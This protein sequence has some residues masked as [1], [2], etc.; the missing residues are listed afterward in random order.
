MISLLG[1]GN[2]AKVV[3]VRYLKNDKIYAMKII[4]KRHDFTK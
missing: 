3:Q 4:K 2:Y 1:K